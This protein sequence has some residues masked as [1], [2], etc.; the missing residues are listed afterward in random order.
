M[1]IGETALLLVD[2]EAP[3][4]EIGKVLEPNEFRP[5]I[6]LANR[7]GDQWPKP[8]NAEDEHCHLM[9]E[10]MEN[11]FLADRNTL[12]AY[13]GQGFKISALPSQSKPVEAI[14]K[15]EVASALEDATAHCETKGR[16]SKGKHSFDLLGRI[17]PSLV[18]V[19]SPWAKRLIDQLKFQMVVA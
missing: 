14:R 18:V 5:W 4:S 7:V 3:I 16:Y 10:C 2:S 15:S 11:W 1:R 9:V 6:H 17:D 8:A 13:F 19:G 12:R